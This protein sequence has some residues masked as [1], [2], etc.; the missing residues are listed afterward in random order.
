MG[1]GDTIVI[2]VDGTEVGRLRIPEREMYQISSTTVHTI[3]LDAKTL[4]LA[5]MPSLL[6]TKDLT[7]G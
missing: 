1:E 5:L 3:N 2:T 7:N 6:K 4:A